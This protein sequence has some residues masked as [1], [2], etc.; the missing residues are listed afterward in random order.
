VFCGLV[1]ALDFGFGF[2]V[3]IDKADFLQL[4][5]VEIDISMG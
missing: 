1:L 5:Q 3:V 2:L 4:D